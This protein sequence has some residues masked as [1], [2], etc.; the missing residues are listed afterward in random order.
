VPQQNQKETI[1][2][3]QTEAPVVSKGVPIFIPEVSIDSQRSSGYADTLSATNEFVDNAIEAGAK[4]VRVY[5]L[6]R[7]KGNRVVSHDIVVLDNGSGMD[8]DTLQRA[9]AFG[10][11]N[12]FDRKGIGRFAYGLPNAAISQGTLLEVYSWQQAGE[13]YKATLD[14]QAVKRGEQPVIAEPEVED[15]PAD[16]SKELMRTVGTFPDADEQKDNLL[17]ADNWPEHGTLVRVSQCDRL[18]WKMTKPYVEHSWVLGRIY[19]YYMWLKGV[20]IFVNNRLIQS[21]DPL[22]LNPKAR[23]SGATPYG[24]PIDI[25]IPVFDPALVEKDEDEA[26]IP[27]VKVQVR[28]SRLPVSWMADDLKV[29]R[30]QRKVYEH[31]QMSVLRADRELEMAFRKLFG[32]GE[33]DPDNWWGGEIHIPAVL[34]DAFGVTNNKQGVHPKH[35]VREILKEALWPTIT[36]LRSKIVADRREERRKRKGGEPSEVEKRLAEAEKFLGAIREVP[37][38]PTY[39][40]QVE[41]E[42]RKFAAKYARDGETA[43]QAYERVMKSPYLVEF[44]DQPE[45]PFYRVETYGTKIVLLINKRHEFYSKLWE[46]LGAATGAPPTGLGE[47]SKAAPDGGTPQDAIAMML[48][49]I[50]RVEVEYRGR[51]QGE[52]WFKEVRQRWSS[53]LQTFLAMLR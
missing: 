2:S 26:K 7:R 34:D 42:L 40:K 25:E 49:A 5:Y 17:T 51:E 10:G 3:T 47:P 36:E 24:P 37:V 22:Y 31:T 39:Q 1:M 18:T 12:R 53:T 46:P 16:L 4:D 33:E 19:R 52:E 14:V 29:N 8:P 20:R 15:V 23:H 35:Y 48:A 21:V 44:V 32:V 43:E 38:D 50:A 27:K 41:Q 9:L 28:L 13:V 11:G 6:P 45:G 30:N